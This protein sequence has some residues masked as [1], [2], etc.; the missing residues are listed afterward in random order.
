M[1]HH[2]VRLMV[3]FGLAVFLVGSFTAVPALAS[4]LKIDTASEGYPCSNGVCRFPPG[5]PSWSYSA[6]ITS[7]GGSGP[8]P[9]TWSVVAG[10]LPDGLSLTPN[11]GVY[12]AYVYGTPT[13]PQTAAFTL[14]VED[15]AGD[16]VADGRDGGQVVLR[17]RVPQ[18][19]PCVH[20]SGTW[21]GTSAGRSSASVAQ[22]TLVIGAKDSR[23]HSASYRGHPRHFGGSGPRK[24][25]RH[26]PVF[27]S[28]P[29]A[30]WSI[31]R[32]VARCS[33]EPFTSTEVVFHPQVM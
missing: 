14:Q 27:L 4:R 23:A 1:K 12:S 10:A 29:L 3:P 15:G 9:Y 33:G 13:T 21:S 8:T 6:P 16:D 5:H 20:S 7:T 11:Y 18:V 30:Q 17:E 25:A 19:G 2:L 22:I 24:T 26:R 31:D 28:H 32:T